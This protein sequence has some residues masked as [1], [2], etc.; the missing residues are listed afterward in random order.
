MGHL[1][2][3]HFHFRSFFTSDNN[4]FQLDELNDSY[5]KELKLALQ[6]AEDYTVKYEEVSPTNQSVQWTSIG[7]AISE[8]NNIFRLQQE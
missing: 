5:D 1:T 7:T 6:Q 4:S 8:P 2:F 3:S